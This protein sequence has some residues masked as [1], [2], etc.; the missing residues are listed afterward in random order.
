MH[1]IVIYTSGVS[2]SEGSYDIS[3]YTY[4]S[5]SDKEIPI[6]LASPGE[7][8]SR[9]S[10]SHAISMLGNSAY[11]YAF[12]TSLQRPALTFFRVSKYAL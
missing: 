11:L 1:K 5:D 3:F 9:P 12:A 10:V 4:F 2:L 8:E 6:R 7:W